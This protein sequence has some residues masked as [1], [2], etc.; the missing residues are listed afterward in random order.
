MKLLLLYFKALWDG[1]GEIK[2]Y[3]AMYRAKKQL[4]GKR[5]IIR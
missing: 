1:Q 4:L 3:Y 2:M 5:S